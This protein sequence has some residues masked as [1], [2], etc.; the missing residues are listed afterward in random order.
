MLHIRLT[1]DRITR[2]APC[3]GERYEEGDMRPCVTGCEA[4][5]DVNRDVSYEDTGD[6]DNAYP[7]SILSWASYLPGS[8]L[9]DEVSDVSPDRPRLL[10]VHRNDEV[11]LD[12]DGIPV[13]VWVVNL[14]PGDP[15]VHFAAAFRSQSEAAALVA[16]QTTVD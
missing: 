11:F 4:H 6:F 5:F 10:T 8:E 2:L 12:S 16:E 3:S 14:R 1:P 9:E 7:S 13:P 15:A